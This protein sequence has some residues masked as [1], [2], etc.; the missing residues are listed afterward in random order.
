MTGQTAGRWKLYKEN[1]VKSV[2][3]SSF[4]GDGKPTDG[5]G[6]DQEVAADLSRIT[7]HTRSSGTTESWLLAYYSPG[8]LPVKTVDTSDTYQ[9]I[10]EYQYDPSGRLM[11]ITNTSLETDNQLKAG[12]APLAI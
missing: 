3:L 8:G 7:T 9:S 12:T 4:E 11:S 1:K 10:S 6:C 2:R 5:F